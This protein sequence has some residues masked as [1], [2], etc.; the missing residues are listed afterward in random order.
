MLIEGKAKGADGADHGAL[1]TKAGLRELAAVVDG[2]G[3]A[4]GRIV[5]WTPAGEQ[6][7][8]TLVQDAHGAGLVVH[9][10]TIRLD[11]LPK[12]C[13]SADALHAALFR[14][15]KSDGVFTDFPD[16]TLAWLKK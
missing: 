16:A 8:T 11:E 14:E 2:I 12:H 10:Y 13:P 9:P 6:Q 15:A 7:V 3:P 4:I 1:C 5:T